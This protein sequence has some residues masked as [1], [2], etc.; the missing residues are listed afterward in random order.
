[1]VVPRAFAW[2]AGFH[3]WLITL[4]LNLDFCE[5]YGHQTKTSRER[6]PGPKTQPRWNSV[7]NRMLHYKHSKFTALKTMQTARETL[8]YQHF[9]AVLRT[10]LSPQNHCRTKVEHKVVFLTSTVSVVQLVMIFCHFS[11]TN[12][13]PISWLGHS[14]PTSQLLLYLHAAKVVVFWWVSVS[15]ANV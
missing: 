13:K 7:G 12:Y 14:S 1:M 5:S 8:R 3:P 6:D 4:P 11:C 15:S 2:W 10:V 9:H